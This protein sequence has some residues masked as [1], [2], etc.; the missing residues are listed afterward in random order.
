MTLSSAEEAFGTTTLY[1]ML[2]IL[3][4][5]NA[6]F[7]RIELRTASSRGGIEEGIRDEG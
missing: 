2:S 3:R 5:R 7:S 4:D 1:N 6:V